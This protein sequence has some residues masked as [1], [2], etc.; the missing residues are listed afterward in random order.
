[1]KRYIGI[2]F[3][4]FLMISCDENDPI[5]VEYENRILEFAYNGD[6]QFPDK[7]YHETISGGS[8]YYENSVSIK[9][10]SERENIWIELSTNDKDEALSWSNSSNGYSSVNREII[11][12]KETKKYFEFKRQNVVFNN[13]ILFSRVHKTSY[14]QPELDKF[15]VPDVVGQYNGD[16]QVDSVKELVEYLWSCGSIGLGHSKVIESKIKEYDTYFEQY[17]QSIKIV[18]GDRGLSD[19][20]HVYDNYFKIDKPNRRVT[21]VSNEIKTIEGQSN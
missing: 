12:E 18:Y 6:Y 5:R 13:D 4:L 10:I 11:S 15:K 19:Y 8:A 20:I 1:M 9:A 2:I 14:F 16:L 17:I 21:L 3:G 7:F